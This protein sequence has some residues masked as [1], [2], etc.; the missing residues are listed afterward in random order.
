MNLVT[1]Q[2]GRQEEGGQRV[3][4][5]AWL[6]AREKT[7]EISSQVSCWYISCINMRCYLRL[8]EFN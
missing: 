8:H 2:G 1:C 3:F 4:D 5:T 6:L 7:A